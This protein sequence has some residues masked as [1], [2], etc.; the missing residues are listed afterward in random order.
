MVNVYATFLL[1]LLLFS[2]ASAAELK[3][4]GELHPGSILVMLQNTAD[5]EVSFALK[6]QLKEKTGGEW[7][8]VETLKCS[9]N[10]S[11]GPLQ[12]KDFNCSYT[13]P[14]ESGQY[15]IYARASIVGSTYT[16]RDFLFNISGNGFVPGQNKL[17]KANNSNSS[18][19]E[20]AGKKE[21][22]IVSI[23]SV[24][25]K[26]KTGEQFFVIV[27]ITSN[28][29]TTLE[30]Y[31]YVYEGKTCYSFLG[32]K[33]NSKK[34]KFTKG[35]TKTLNLTDIVSHDAVNGTYQLKVRARE[36]VGA[37]FKDH[38][39]VKTIEVEQVPVDLF[40]E[41]PKEAKKPEADGGLPIQLL[42]P[43]FG[44]IPLVAIILKKI[45]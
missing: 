2:L 3:L 7:K 42:L 34:Y 18:V 14:I 36:T 35:E 21:D 12:Q 29:D 11:V 23:I 20:A 45:L 27:N 25:D 22:V 24:P 39:I 16:Y 19:F 40:K 37:G 8:L 1:I 43:L 26:V 9:T 28:K 44:S 4:T 15:K 10:S 31:S 32:W 13:T 17:K 38:D 33:G 6:L 30:I 41:L 5:R